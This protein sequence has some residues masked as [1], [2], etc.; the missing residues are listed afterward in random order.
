MKPAG[1]NITFF[2]AGVVLGVAV[3]IQIPRF[4]A[5]QRE[6][7]HHPDYAEGALTKTGD[8]FHIA[9]GGRGYFAFLYPNGSTVYSRISEFKLNSAGFLVSKH[10]YSFYGGIGGL[11]GVV[12]FFVSPEGMVRIIQKPIYLETQVGQINLAIFPN[13]D[14]L[15]PTKDG[16]FYETPESGKPV[17]NS[18]LQNGS[19]PLLQG[20]KLESKIPPNT[21]NYL[22]INGPVYDGVND[23]QQEN[24]IPTGR[25]LDYGIEGPGFLEVVLPDGSTG[26][27]RYLSLVPSEVGSIVRKFP[28]TMAALTG[29]PLRHEKIPIREMPLARFPSPENLHYFLNGVY[30]ETELSGPAVQKKQ[31]E[32]GTGVLKQGFLNDVPRVEP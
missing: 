11:A 28:Y 6:H 31:G 8:P 4:L 23:R 12:S 18:P 9:I 17:F 21:P 7:F 2:I 3:T 22:I 32:D 24:L 29:I 25:D 20:Y 1:T 14:G 5:A 26:Y 27:T 19:G 15:K 10:G 16:Y 13:P 30:E